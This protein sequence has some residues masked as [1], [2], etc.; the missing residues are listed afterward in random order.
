MLRGAQKKL[1]LASAGEERPRL[2]VTATAAGRDGP[3]LP[4]YLL[5]PKAK[6]ADPP[7]LAPSDHIVL[8]DQG[9]EWFRARLTKHT[10][11]YRNYSY[12]WGYYVL[13]AD[14]ADAAA[15]DADEHWAYLH[16]GEDWGVLRGLDT[17][18]DLSRLDPQL[19][20]GPQIPHILTTACETCNGGEVKVFEEEKAHL[21]QQLPFTCAHGRHVTAIRP[22]VST[23][24]PFLPTPRPGYPRLAASVPGPEATLHLAAAST[25]ASSMTGPRIEARFK[26]VRN[27]LGKVV[28]SHADLEVAIDDCREGEI[29]GYKDLQQEEMDRYLLPLEDEVE[30][31]EHRAEA[32]V[33]SLNNLADVE[34]DV[35]AAEQEEARRQEAQLARQEEQEEARSQEAQIARQEEQ[36]EARRQE[37]QLAMQQE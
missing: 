13:P 28:D 3:L 19:P 16:P 32:I 4:Y 2:D 34:E 12:Y 27:Q 21:Q 1:Q 10:P 26:E 11:D 5:Q 17:A 37:A 22:G 25:V 9:G 29:S 7:Y 15:G 33:V 31:L 18:L 23:E 30:E 20:A 6:A 35:V 24:G 36:E 8:R 14:E